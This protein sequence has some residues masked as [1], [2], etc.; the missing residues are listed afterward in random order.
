MFEIAREEV[1][2]YSGLFSSSSRSSDSHASSTKYQ[3][4][5]FCVLSSGETF[6]KREEEAHNDEGKGDEEGTKERAPKICS[7]R[8]SVCLA[9]L[10]LLREVRFFYSLSPIIFSLSLGNRHRLR[11]GGGTNRDRSER[12]SENARARRR[13]TT[14]RII[15][16]ANENWHKSS[17]RKIGTTPRSGSARRTNERRK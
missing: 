6:L 13:T 11:E 9:V 15:K 17:P 3:K 1:F 4:Q 2:F 12:G 16:W 14:P 8:L 10:L 5:L 7:L